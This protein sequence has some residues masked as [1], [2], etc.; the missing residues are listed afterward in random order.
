MENLLQVLGVFRFLYRW[1]LAEGVVRG[2]EVLALVGGL[3]GGGGG[4]AI[5]VVAVVGIGEGEIDLGVDTLFGGDE[6]PVNG[7]KVGSSEGCS[8]R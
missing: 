2:W 4:G 8:C 7:D 3:R 5:F 6:M 1:L